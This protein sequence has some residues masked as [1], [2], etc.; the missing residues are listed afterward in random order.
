ML[1]IATARRYASWAGAKSS[2]EFGDS[3]LNRR[4]SAH[5]IA[6]AFYTS[7]MRQ[8]LLC[9]GD[10]K[11]CRVP[12]CPVRQPAYSRLQYCLATVGDGSNQIGVTPMTS[13]RLSNLIT[14]N[15][16]SRAAAHRAM[17]KAALFADSSTRTRLK[18]YNHH[19]E[20]AR[21]LEAEQAHI[22][23]SRLMQAYDTLRAEN[24]EV[25]Q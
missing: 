17:A 22:R 15:L 18:R 2:A 6:G 3:E 19:T 11:V 9:V 4:N 21:A 10:R 8:W 25:N 7:A 24:A 1:T 12:I 14:R 16:S 23:R 20:K 5:H 13:L